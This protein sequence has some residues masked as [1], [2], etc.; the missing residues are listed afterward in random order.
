MPFTIYIAYVALEKLKIKLWFGKTL[1]LIAFM[2]LGGN[3]ILFG[4]QFPNSKIMI[5]YILSHS[6]IL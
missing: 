5:L 6:T 4:S 1:I 3:F 2:I